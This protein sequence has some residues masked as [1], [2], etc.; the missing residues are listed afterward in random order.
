MTAEL[1]VHAVGKRKNAIARVYLRPGTGRI[2]VND[3]SL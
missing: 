1:N 2:T 3:R